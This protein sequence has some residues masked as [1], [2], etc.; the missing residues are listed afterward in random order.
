MASL[1]GQNP[2]ATFPSLIKTFNNQPL[3]ASLVQLSDG[4]GVTTPISVST[5]NVSISSPLTASIIAATDNGN[6]TNFKIGDDIFLGD[7]NISNTFQVK[8]VGD[9]TQ[10]FVKFGSG[11][12]SPIVG[13]VAGASTFQVS[14]SLNV[15]SS[16]TSTISAFNPTL[17]NNNGV[18]IKG[19]NSF[20]RLT[21]NTGIWADGIQSSYVQ[22]SGSYGRYVSVLGGLAGTDSIIQRLQVASQYT[23]FVTSSIGSTP[24]P[25]HL[26]EVLGGDLYISNSVT[27]SI[28]HAN[29]NGN[30]TN[31]KVG[32]DAWIGDVNIANTF[33]IMGQEDATQGF[34]KFGSGSNSTIVGGVAGSNVFQV[35]GSIAVSTVLSLKPQS[36]LPAASSAPYSFAVSSST[37]AKPYFSDGTNWNALY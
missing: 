2:S 25:T 13:G 35:T 9:G 7:V 32:D 12:N 22:F 1:S 33:Q 34:I 37:P 24:V 10:G 6:G 17:I 28:V 16:I 14:G 21:D 31:F 20:L 4:N 15:S 27:A 23:Q 5:V 3:S 8:G 29:N 18:V 36:P 26:L 11:S 19:G 30:G